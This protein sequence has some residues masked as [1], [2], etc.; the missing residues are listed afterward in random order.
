MSM[1][2][3]QHLKLSQQL[4][5]TPQLQQAIKLLQLSRMELVDMIRDEMLENPVLEDSVESQAEQQKATPAELAADTQAERIGETDSPVGEP[6][7]EK[8]METTAEVKADTRS[9][10]AVKDFDWEAYLENQASS[11]PLPSYRANSDDLPSLESTLTRGTSLFGHLE[12]QIKLGHF[13]QQEE[14]VALLIIGNLTPD[15]YL[16]QPL[17]EIAEEASVP[18]EFAEAVLEEGAGA[19]PPGRRGPQPAGVPPASRPNTWGPTTTS[20]SES[21][22]GTSGIWRRRTTARSPRTSTSRSTRSTRRPR[23]SWRSTPSR[24]APTPTRI[25]P[26]SPRMCSS[27]RSARSTSWWPTT[28]ACR[29]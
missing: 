29:S 24:D 14:A 7:S 27:T 16:D 15:G 28:T 6:L 25:R 13:V 9:D 23:W 22:R 21:S 19:G 20:S 17:D 10:E 18:L 11:P 8:M 3:K 12:W 26:T 4:V 2:I 5:M 1:E